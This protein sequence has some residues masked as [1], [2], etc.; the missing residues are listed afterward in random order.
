MRIEN[1]QQDSA[2]CTLREYVI[3]GAPEAQARILTN[4]NNFFEQV[5]ANALFMP[6]V[7]QHKLTSN[8]I[9]A[10][11]MKDSICGVAFARPHSLE[12][13]PAMAELNADADATQVISAIRKLPDGRYAGALFDSIG[14]AA[15]LHEQGLSF[16]GRRVLILGAGTQSC[17]VAL[18][19]V[20]HGA[21]HL[22]V[23]DPRQYLAER[24]ISQLRGL[25]SASLGTDMRAAQYDVMVNT[26]E[27]HSPLQPN[28]L[29]SYLQKINPKGW[30]V[31]TGLS[32][33]HSGF[34]KTA[35]SLGIHTFSGI[36][37]LRR[38]VRYYLQFFGELGRL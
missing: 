25:G 18:A 13:C 9:T 30:A 28:L 10:V 16:K 36:P 1:D 38:Q 22:D 15:H 6:S 4:F 20:Q 23:M 2:R 24:L 26:W 34:L 32:L 8:A 12:E 17:A 5:D 27:N 14:L 11:L 31:D 37:S 21:S 19:A 29:A 33:E 7:A 35:R 3:F